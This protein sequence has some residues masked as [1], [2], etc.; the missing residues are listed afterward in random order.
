M[1]DSI[2]FSI[3]NPNA[4][5]IN[6]PDLFL[7]KDTT[8]LFV[9]EF[10]AGLGISQLAPGDLFTIIIPDS[11]LS[12]A[13]AGN[14]SDPDWEVQS[15]TLPSSNDPNYTFVLTPQSSIQVNDN[16]GITFKKMQGKATG[17]GEV[18][19]QYNI[20]GVTL[21]GSSEKLFVLTA[22]NGQLKDLNDDV[23]FTAFINYDQQLV[24]HD[25]VYISPENLQPPI[26][27]RIHLNLAYNGHDNLIP[28]WPPLSPPQFIISFSYGTGSNDLTDAIQ[29]GHTDYNALTSAWSIKGAID[30]AENT[31]WNLPL[32][33]TSDPSPSWVVEPAFGNQ[34]L[35]AHD[36]NLDVIFE[37]IITILP[38]GVAHLYVQWANIPGYNA[39]VRAVALNKQV[40]QQ[41][42]LDFTSPQDG[43]TIDP[44]TPVT[45]NWQAFAAENLKITWDGG[46]QSMPLTAYDQNHP[47]L[48]YSGSSDA[49]VPDSPDTAFF[50]S[51]NNGAVQGG[52]VNVSVNNFPAPTISQFSFDVEHGTEDPSQ[53]VIKFS[54]LV[55]NLGN[56]GHFLLD[57]DYIDGKLYNGK[58][59]TKSI[60]LPPSKLVN[61]QSTLVAVD[62][63]NNL[64]STKTTDIALPDWFM[65]DVL[66]FSGTV[67]RDANNVLTLELKW[68][69][70]YAVPGST[71]CQINGAGA[72]PLDAQGNGSV[73]IPISKTAPLLNQ[74]TLSAK[75][76]GPA[77]P[78]AKTLKVNFAPAH[79]IGEANGWEASALTITPDGSTCWALFMMKYNTPSTRFKDGGIGGYLVL[80]PFNTESLNYVGAAQPTSFWVSSNDD[81]YDQYYRKITL[82]PD[83]NYI[84]IMAIL[85]LFCVQILPQ[86]FKVVDVLLG[87][88]PFKNDPVDGQSVF[89]P[90]MSLVFLS[91]SWVK[92]DVLYYFDPRE[93][94]KYPVYTNSPGWGDQTEGSLTPKSIQASGPLQVEG[95]GV[96]S[97]GKRVFL[98][99]YIG[100][101]IWWFDTDNI[102]SSLSN[103]FAIKF[104]PI[105][106]LSKNNWL[107]WYYNFD[108]NYLRALNVSDTVDFDKR[109]KL[110]SFGSDSPPRTFTVS[111]DDS[112][113]LA[114]STQQLAVITGVAL[115][116][117]GSAAVLQV[118]PIVD[119]Q[120]LVITPDNTRIFI[121]AGDSIQVWEPVL[122]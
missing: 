68:Q 67:N 106:T 6:A 111:E 15:L 114:L 45:L 31:A 85:Q 122:I 75:N 43:K 30:Q 72:Y 83:G 101:K 50:L 49:I 18:N 51:A 93:I 24:A 58:L 94:S 36:Q 99:D 109:L 8:L 82:S 107:Y 59:F 112:F 113:V 80:N 41:A 64:S 4:Q 52:P 62:Q 16:V 98:C 100:R 27:N 46:N 73:S 89:L 11:L 81:A 65:P 84:Y 47:Q 21:S 37:Q 12:S 53:V 3:Q 95:F 48:I 34:H 20:G 39:G 92:K 102:P 2:T 70:A 71:I 116:A 10:P 17:Q 28:N 119:A 110:P 115:P 96:R 61:P 118:T 103:S 86:T 5:P 44:N 63:T 74:Y 32:P 40:P 105:V 38:K 23:D 66:A 91:G 9:F 120:S 14:L 26:A 7:G 13:L 97:D 87:H 19:T 104:E 35:L 108:Q 76:P 60:P 1:D 56:D 69:L 55:N 117:G 77:L 33:N 29:S 22:P 42:K 121:A 90:D 54:W 25:L 78:T 79:T 57:G 88:L